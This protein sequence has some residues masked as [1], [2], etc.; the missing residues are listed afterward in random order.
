VGLQARKGAIAAG[1]DADL[2]IWNPDEQFVVD[3]SL[4]HHRH[5]I[6]PYHGETL[7]GV[8]QKSFL[9]GRKIYEHGAFAFPP[10][11]RLLL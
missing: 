1:R 2:V 8:V 11:G 7:T 3:A 6:T 4:L 9:R 10:A 5:K